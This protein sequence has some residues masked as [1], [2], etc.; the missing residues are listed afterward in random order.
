MS[1]PLKR[2]VMV[3]YSQRKASSAFH[4]AY[5]FSPVQ[6]LSKSLPPFENTQSFWPPTLAGSE[7]EHRKSIGN[8][9]THVHRKAARRRGV[10]RD[11][12]GRDEDCSVG[13]L[14]DDSRAT[15]LSELLQHSQ[16]SGT[17]I[18]LWSIF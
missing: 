4:P 1:S 5:I 9:L 12:V 2:G 6:F 3:D 11:S 18:S 17:L 13:A 14:A 16:V 15:R 7:H 10:E 8:D